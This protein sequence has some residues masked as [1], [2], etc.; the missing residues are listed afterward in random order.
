MLL[1]LWDSVILLCLVVRCFVS[2]L[3]HSFA[4]I[5]MG[6]RELVVLL[7]FSSLCLLI[8]V[9]LVLMV[10]RGCLQFVI[11]VFPDHIFPVCGMIT[12]TQALLI[13]V[14]NVHVSCLSLIVS[15]SCSLQ[16]QKRSHSLSHC[17]QETKT[18]FT[19]IVIQPRQKLPIIEV[20]FC[21]QMLIKLLSYF[22]NSEYSYVLQ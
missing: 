20:L 19:R 13:Y 11:I 8:A 16:Y 17:I 14:L 1:P 10:Q 12:H 21:I 18:P 5:L 15:P 9:W 2:I 3:P 22:G 4:I 7:C 6:K